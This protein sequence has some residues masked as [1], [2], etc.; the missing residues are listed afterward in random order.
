MEI[1]H[2]LFRLARKDQRMRLGS[3]KTP[4]L[5]GK[6]VLASIINNTNPCEKKRMKKN[7]DDD[8]GI[9]KNR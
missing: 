3:K 7:D 5:H 6:E 8:D 9:E 4:L 2:S 1:S